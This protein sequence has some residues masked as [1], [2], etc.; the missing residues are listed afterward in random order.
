LR[1]VAGRLRGRRLAAPPGE[2]LR[3]TS[4]RARESL[5]NILASGAHGGPELVGC[6]FLDGFCGTG[7]AAIEAL[8]RGANHAT[9]IDRDLA[10]ARANIAALDLARETSL[11]AA[12]LAH[13]G[14]RPAGGSGTADIVFL[15]P[16]YGSGLGLPA[17]RAL[18][19]GGW[20][21]AE[22]LI[23]LESAARAPAE[24][25]GDS[26]FLVL[27]ERRY[28]AARLSFLRRADL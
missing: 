18:A 19:K 11:V 9:L 5:F 24:D 20:L 10:P 7:A 14:A 15:D 2:R 27:E 3:P 6:H 12:D 28:G 23:V 17:L 1:V 16:P 22:A 8:S 13:I 21:A 26:G 25:L 4:D